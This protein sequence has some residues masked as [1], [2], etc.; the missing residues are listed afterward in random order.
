MKQ[1]KT[2][3]SDLF[4]LFMVVFYFIFSGILVFTNI[5]TAVL[6]KNYCYILGAVFFIYGTF[7]TYRYFRINKR[8]S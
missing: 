4:G 5:F 7:R 2:T 1:M 3:F 8:Q 6:S